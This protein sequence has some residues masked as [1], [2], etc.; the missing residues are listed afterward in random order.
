MKTLTTTN[1]VRVLKLE[2]LIFRIKAQAMIAVLSTVLCSCSHYYY[3]ANTKNVPMLREKNEARVSISYG[4]GD[5]SS[6]FDAQGAYAITDKIGV[7]ANYMT[8]SGGST[9]SPGNNWAKGTCFEGAAGYFKPI[10]TFGVFEV[11]GGLGTS[12]QHHQY[13]SGTADLR[14]LKV[15]V[16]PSFGFTWKWGE[17]AF[18]LPA[19]RVSFNEIRDYTSSGEHSG[20]EK[21]ASN[22]ISYILEP[23]VT[24]RGGWKYLKLQFQYVHVTNLTNQDLPFECDKVSL[25][26]YISIARRYGNDFQSKSK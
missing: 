9:S 22:K 17:L 10:N 4:E 23:A 14:F 1:F 15:F 20:L 19:S 3:V 6:S 16:Q 12:S 8:A 2:G 18:S 21:I 7:L 25:G 24:I 5:E 13:S 26:L 11:Y